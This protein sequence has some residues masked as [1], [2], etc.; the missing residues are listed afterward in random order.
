MTMIYAL[1]ETET[2]KL[3]SWTRSA[4]GLPDAATRTA[5]GWTVVEIKDVDPSGI[6]NPATLTWDP[7]PVEAVMLTEFQFKARLTADERIAIRDAAKT[8]PYVDDFLDLLASADEVN[9]RDDL[10][11][12]AVGYLAMRGLLT[13]ERAAEVLA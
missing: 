3:L 8:D 7:R 11:I 9:L 2:G 1:V 4:A 12:N 5:R 13:E 6:W 10:V